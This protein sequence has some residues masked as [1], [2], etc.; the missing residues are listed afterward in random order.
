MAAAALPF[1]LVANCRE[2]VWLTLGGALC[3]LHAA[4]SMCKVSR[5]CCVKQFP[6]QITITV[7]FGPL[8]FCSLPISPYIASVHL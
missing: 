7:I 1:W 4:N 2:S 8:G 5:D 3:Q 6:D